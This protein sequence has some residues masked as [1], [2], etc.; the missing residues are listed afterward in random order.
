MAPL[1]DRLF[2]DTPNERDAFGNS[3]GVHPALGLEYPSTGLQRPAEPDGNWRDC[4]AESNGLINNAPNPAR[5]EPRTSFH[6]GT[7]IT[8]G[9]INN[10]HIQHHGEAGL[11]IL[12]RGSAIDALHDSGE[13]FPPPRCHP[14][15]R[16][17]L[18]DDVWN[19]VCGN[20][21]RR[22]TTS[23]WDDY[24]DNWDQTAETRPDRKILW[25]YGPAGA[26][27]SAVAQTLCQRLQEGGRLG[28]SFFFKRGHLSRGNAKKLFPTIAYQL[29]IVHP[30]LNRA[31]SQTVESDPATLDKSFSLQLE[32]LIVEPCCKALLDE[33]FCVVIDGLDECD[34]DIIQQEILR[35]ISHAFHQ[36][37]IPLLFFIASR[38]EPHIQEVFNHP[39]VAGFHHS[40][41]IQQSF[42]DVRK[43]LQDEFHRIHGEHS[44]TMATVP[45]PWPSTA[46][47]DHL[48]EKSSGYFIYAATII[49]FIDDKDFRPTE[50]LNVIMGISTPESAEDESPFWPLD[51]LYIEV[52]SQT[53][54]VNRPRLFKILAVALSD[55]DLGIDHIEQL[56]E[57]KSGD[58]RLSF[59]G[60]HSVLKIQED[61]RVKVH[62][63]S[64]HDFLS[65]PNRSGEFHVGSVHLHACITEKILKAFAHDNLL[66]RISHVAWHLDVA[67]L[68]Y[69]SSSTPSPDLV[70]LLESFNPDFLFAM[71]YRRDPGYSIDEIFEW[72]K[73]FQPLPT[74][75]IQLWE[76]YKFM[77]T[78]QQVCQYASPKKQ[79]SKNCPDVSLLVSPQPIRIYSTYKIFDGLVRVT[80]RGP[81]IPLTD[82]HVRFNLSW[83]DLRTVICPLR[84]FIGE[85]SEDLANFLILASDPSN[86]P[87]FHFDSILRD[88]AVG[89]LRVLKETAIA[90]ACTDGVSF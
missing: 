10:T 2:I 28:G 75:S 77:W 79:N 25:L 26:G 4:P 35:S 69:I 56:L 84:S 80:G 21:S 90:G 66:D 47:L 24:P 67:G 63:A 40:V 27:K 72:L 43:H 51:Q 82:I 9:N 81:L 37:R 8:A 30:E 38:P 88:L 41:N 15:T 23:A 64:F 48:V 1:S 3:L 6:G 14:E 11:H 74:C 65:N 62:H 7:F 22:H 31:I 54:L 45:L 87:T 85:D 20:E 36:S 16:M 50:R 39:S 13:R 29:A 89:G 46:V 55:L 42:H 83:D 18:L 34:S 70:P 17:E 71:D 32:K 5:E 61:G 44:E 53:P 78:F 57:I 58:V 60:L 19:W 49:R 52:L 73:K 86:L 33:P 59:R 76:D 68:R 12:H